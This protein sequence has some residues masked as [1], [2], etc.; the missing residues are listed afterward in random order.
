MADSTDDPLREATSRISELWDAAYPGEGDRHNRRRA[1]MGLAW[2]AV[3]RYRSYVGFALEERDVW[4]EGFIRNVQ[5]NQG[6]VIGGEGDRTLADLYEERTEL[7]LHAHYAIECF[8]IFGKILL[9]RIAVAIRETFGN[10]AGF[11]PSHGI[12]WHESKGLSAFAQAHGLP[13][14]PADLLERAEELEEITRFRD[15]QI[16]HIQNVRHARGTLYMPGVGV[17][18]VVGV[19]MPKEDESPPS[20]S[21]TVAK[22]IDLLDEH[23][24]AVTEWV[25]QCLAGLAVP[26]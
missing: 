8:F 6:L 7:T 14:P 24:S 1:R 25:E 17:D 3:R 19:H 18:L 15:H 12:L 22:T 2:E 4:G 21:P 23:L 11:E 26:S 20:D 10:A 16:A 13:S 9:D 5:A